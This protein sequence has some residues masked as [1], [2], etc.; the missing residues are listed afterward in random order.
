MFSKLPFSYFQEFFSDQLGLYTVQNYIEVFVFSF[1]IYQILRWLQQDHTK[2]LVLYVYGY[3]SVMI[4]SQLTGCITLFWTMF[5]LMPIAIMTCIIMH[6]KQLQKNFI[7][8]SSKDLT[9]HTLPTKNWLDLFIRSCLLA[10]YQHKQFYCIIERTDHLAPLLH[11]PC[12]LYL[13]LQQ[14]II[15]LIL[16]SNALDNPSILWM[17]DSGILHS[18]NATWQKILTNEILSPENQPVHHGEI[19]LLT[20]KTD[21]LVFSIDPTA[22]LAM[23]WYQGKSMQKLTIDQLMTSCK[24]ILNKKTENQILKKQ[25]TSYAKQ[26]S[27]THSS[28]KLH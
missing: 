9:P 4:A 14:N 6:Q 7:L 22:K 10:A 2:H 1:F 18:V 27:A 12:N 19:I 8:A 24:Q 5:I 13:A 15:D 11:A 28:S 23:L 3:A 26:D 16:A 25:G 17:T 20:A 21:A